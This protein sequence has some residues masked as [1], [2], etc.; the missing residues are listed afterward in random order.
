MFK[1]IVSFRVSYEYEIQII[2]HLYNF[3]TFI[4]IRTCD[5]RYYTFLGCTSEIISH[6]FTFITFTH[7]NVHYS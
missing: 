2:K 7:M 1:H 3:N 5:S 4:L 6:A